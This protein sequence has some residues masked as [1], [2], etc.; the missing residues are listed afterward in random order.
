MEFQSDTINELASALAK[1]QGEF[2][3]AELD[4]Q[5]HFG[6]YS[7]FE[8]LVK[9]TRPVLV[10]HGLSVTQK[11]MHIDGTDFMQ[12]ILLH[13]SGQYTAS[14][15]RL[16]L[17]KNDNPS[18]SSAVTWMKRLS[19]GAILGVITHDGSVEEVDEPTPDTLNDAEL[20]QLAAELEGFPM[21]AQKLLT[22]CGVRRLADVPRIKFQEYLKHI[23]QQKK[24]GSLK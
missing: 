20:R 15:A 6:G 10:K 3:Q 23:Q 13:S 9:A 19:Y 14:H 17:A 21:I 8:S 11:I 12:T 2:T 18:L 24:A 1:A 16:W 22:A 5:G 4:S 7:S